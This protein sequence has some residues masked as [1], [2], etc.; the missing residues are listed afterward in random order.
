MIQHSIARGFSPKPSSKNA[1]LF[2]SLC[3]WACCLSLPYTEPSLTL[4]AWDSNMVSI[5]NSFSVYYIRASFLACR[6]L[7]GLFSLHLTKKKKEELGGL[8]FL[9]EMRKLTNLLKSDHNKLR[10]NTW[11]RQTA[12]KLLGYWII[13]VPCWKEL[14]GAAIILPNKCVH[15]AVLLHMKLLWFSSEAGLPPQSPISTCK[16]C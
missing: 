10:R 11:K 12:L 15:Y 14:G 6:N 1:A 13:Q 4:H 7:S 3:G 9:K 2:L 16:S 8:L 5:A